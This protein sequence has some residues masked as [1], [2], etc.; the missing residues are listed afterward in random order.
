MDLQKQHPVIGDVRGQGLMI[1][2]ELVEPGTKT[3]LTTSKVNDI[4]ENIKDNGVLIAR[5][6]RFNNVSLLITATIQIFKELYVIM[7]CNQ[8]YKSII[9]WTKGVEKGIKIKIS[10]FKASYIFYKEIY[11]QPFAFLA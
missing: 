9:M 5:G 3:P 10:I 7:F 11:L 2:V 4:H 1:G 6:G 8:S